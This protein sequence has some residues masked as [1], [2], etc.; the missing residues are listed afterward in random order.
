MCTVKRG[1]YVISIRLPSIFFINF[2][3]AGY[4]KYMIGPVKMT[5]E[6]TIIVC[7]SAGALA[8]H[9]AA[10]IDY[11][12]NLD[13]KRPDFSMRINP[14]TVDDPSLHVTEK[15]SPIIE[16]RKVKK[17][18]DYEAEDSAISVLYTTQETV[19]VI[20]QYPTAIIIDVLTQTADKVQQSCNYILEECV[21]S[22]GCLIN[23]NNEI[24]ETKKILGLSNIDETAMFADPQFAD[25]EFLQVLIFVLA[26][27]T[28]FI[29]SRSQVTGADWH[30]YF[31]VN[32][33]SICCAGKNAE[34][35]Q[36]AFDN[37]LQF[38]GKKSMR[39]AGQAFAVWHQLLLRLND[40]TKLQLN[41][42]NWSN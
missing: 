37:L 14:V 3:P 12:V 20:E 29:S 25:N 34:N 30:T 13:S 39:P 21:R 16:P 7:A 38:L 4:H 28:S 33:D 8:R 35:S 5:P 41:T 17:S 27:N 10:V 26:N 15:I 36:E 24:A 40:S 32:F 22:V 42:G 23:A 18:W 6:N 19:K 11:A 9:L 31:A 2:A 1:K